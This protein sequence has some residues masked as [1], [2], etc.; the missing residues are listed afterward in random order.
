[1]PWAGPRVTVLDGDAAGGKAASVN[2]G[3]RAATGEVL[4]F[5]DTQQRFE[6]EAIDA[7]VASL[8][9][10]PRGDGGRR[11]AAPAG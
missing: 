1:M 2:A 7:L 5:T 6:P 8:Q 11:C 3:V 4:V 9:S 10:H